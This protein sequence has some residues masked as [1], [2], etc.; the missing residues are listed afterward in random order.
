MDS[1]HT[2]HLCRAIKAK[3]GLTSSITL[4]LVYKYP[5]VELLAKE[6]LQRENPAGQPKENTE[7]DR[8]EAMGTL[9]KHY[10]Q[11]VD[12]LIYQGA[13]PTT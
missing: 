8:L 4:S 2:L 5:S 1:L 6:I 7:Q 12:Q 11:Q 3:L 13:R 10:E 9:L